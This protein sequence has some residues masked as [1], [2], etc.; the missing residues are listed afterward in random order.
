MPD[1][2]GGAG[3]R[4]GSLREFLPE[5]EEILDRL[6]DDLRE[7]E[8][9]FAAGQP[10]LEVV[11]TIF[12]DTHSLKG[13]AGLLGFPDITSL[14]HELEDLLS[15]LRLGG[16]L[17]RAVLDLLI[18][19]VDA[20][21]ETLRGLRSRA[22]ARRELGPLRERLR[23]AGA[24]EPGTAGNVDRLDLPPAILAALTEFEE[25]R[26]GE[27]HGR[28]RRLALVR[29]QTDAQRLDTDL[30]EVRRRAGEI[31]ELIATLPVTGLP[32]ALLAF[33][34]L[35]ASERPLRPDDWTPGLIVGVRDLVPGAGE[36][37]AAKPEASRV[38]EAGL[39][40]LGSPAGLLRVPVGRLD[41][42]LARAGDLSI[43]IA[44]LESRVRSVRERHADDH[45][46]RELEPLTQAIMKRLNALQRGVIDARLVPLDQV[47]RKIG[48]VVARVARSGGKEADL[49]TLGA[50][51]EIDK[52]V[53]D[54]LAPPL[55][56][57]T[58]N[59]LDHGIEPPDERERAGK[60]RRGRVVLSA[61]RRG[62]SVVI[63]I[64]DDGRGIGVEATRAA[65]EACG[66]I[67]P[68]QPITR[69]QA[70]ELIFQPGFS[71]ATR[72]SEVSGR[73]VGLDVVRRSLR[74]LKGSI[75]VRSVEGQGT[76]F[77]LTVPISLSLVPAIIV[78]SMGRHFAI[79]VG[80]IRE[81]LR[82]DGSRLR[83]GAGAEAEVYDHPDGPLRLFRLD[84]LL[85]RRGFPAPGGE[86]RYAIVAGSGARRAGIIVD[87]LIGSQEVVVKPVGRWLQ[88]SPGVAGATDLGN[89]G[90]ALVLDPE[91]LVA[92]AS[93]GH[94]V[95]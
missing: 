66:L 18:D 26:L 60:P 72:V 42:I 53:M 1:E 17:D 93:D 45:R 40:E 34:L 37:S 46:V 27:S 15:R 68:G 30:E 35:V 62:P 33:D 3:D 31:G 36:P 44:S 2:G 10:C 87:D 49:H 24:I 92:G 83:P 85:A 16:G 29:L 81:S 8:T 32:D 57:L 63:D 50:D 47:F 55:L 7:L 13:F 65:A 61:F 95:S 54:A 64:V 58:T 12:R 20:L 70:E 88:D 80:S 86:A 69:E 78:R 91:A 82:I 51:T 41:E 25:R 28:G 23:R 73:G 76:T 52:S 90:A 43:A 48:R 59:A 79:P 67:R 14:S 71:T 22:P 84:R 4:E 75:V 9:V 5:A 39:E 56:H 21:F 74:R 38:S 89:A 19:T 94:A 11:N 77:T 6:S